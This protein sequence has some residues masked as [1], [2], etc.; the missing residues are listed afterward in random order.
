M[1]DAALIAGLK[2]MR[3][4]HETTATALAYGIFKTAEFTDD[5][6]NVVFVDV[7]HSSLQAGAYTRPLFS[8]T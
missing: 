7:G 1:L 3:L 6:T 8:S 5:P 4:M 2:V